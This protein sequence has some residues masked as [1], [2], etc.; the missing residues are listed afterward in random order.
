MCF[1]FSLPVKLNGKEED[2]FPSDFY[3]EITFLDVALLDVPL[4][5]INQCEDIVNVED[6]SDEDSFA[7]DF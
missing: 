1:E 7:Y 6:G 4:S 5:M 3:D 2:V